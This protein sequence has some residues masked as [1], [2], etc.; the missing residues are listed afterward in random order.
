MDRRTSYTQNLIRKSLLSLMQH[1]PFT[2]ITGTEICKLAEINRGT[3]YLHYDDLDDVP[4]DIA[5]KI[6]QDTTQ[7]FDHVMCPEKERCTNPFCQKVQESQE[8]RILFS[9][10]TPR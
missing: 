5:E 8:F 2:K 9:D 3:F 10:D 1:K 4:D 6:I 7:V